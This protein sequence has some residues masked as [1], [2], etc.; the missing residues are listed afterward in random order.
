MTQDNYK[1][2]A[3]YSSPNPCTWCDGCGDYGIWTAVKR[4]CAEL[5]LDPSEVLMCFDIGCHGNMSDKVGG[6]Y[7]FHGLHGRVLPFAAGAK[8][9]NPKV[10]TIAFAGDGAPFSEGMNHLVH[11]VR[12]NYP[13]VCL[14]HN[15]ENYGL[16]TGQASAVTRQDTPMN[17]SPNGIPEATLSPMDLVFSLSPTFVARGTSCDI[18]QLTEII[19]E[20]IQHD[21]FAYI[22]VLQ[23]CPTYNKFMTAEFLREHCY[24]VGS[25]YDASDFENARR[26]AI[27]TSEKIATGVLYH[28][29]DPRPSFVGRLKSRDGKKSSLVEEVEKGDVGG[30]MQEMV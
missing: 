1:S 4:A 6:C 27:D 15:N 5:E 22:D 13:I 3:K 9:A 28:A 19:K 17:S 14:L 21:G 25:D 24:A 11:S 30:F 12:S 2:M 7:R 10:N 18:K 29:K 23:S 16:T 20:G 8:S 26:T